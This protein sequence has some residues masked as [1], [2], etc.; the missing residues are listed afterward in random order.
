MPSTESCGRLPGL[1]LQLAILRASTDRELDAA[2]DSR[3]LVQAGARVI[4]I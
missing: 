4:S 3:T 2:F 1:G